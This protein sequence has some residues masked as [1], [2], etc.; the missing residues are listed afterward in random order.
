LNSAADD[1]F[2]EANEIC[3][4]IVEPTGVYCADNLAFLF[5]RAESLHSARSN[6]VA[7]LLVDWVI[8][9]HDG[10]QSNRSVAARSIG[11]RH[12]RVSETLV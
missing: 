3:A 7:E 11:F 9:G 8:D 4:R 10:N 6:R 5:R 1:R 12:C 2:F